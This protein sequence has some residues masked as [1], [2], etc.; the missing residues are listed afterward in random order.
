MNEKFNKELNLIK[1]WMK[2]VNQIIYIVSIVASKE[3]KDI[4]NNK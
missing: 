4:R 2:T 1:S 3:E